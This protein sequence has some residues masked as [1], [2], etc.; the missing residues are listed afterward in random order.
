MRVRQLHS[1]DVTTTQA[2]DLQRR[3]AND[4]ITTSGSTPDDIDEIQ[5]VAGVDLSP[6]D[7]ETGLVRG[8]A[9]VLSFP[10]LEIV[11]VSTAQGVPEFP[12]VPGLLSF[13]EAPV[14]AEALAA[15][16]VTPDLVLV[17]GQGTAHPRRFGLACHLGLMIDVP[18]IGCAKSRLVGAHDQPPNERGASV[19]LIHR[20]EPI[21]AAVRTRTGVSPIYVS[22]GHRISLGNA[23]H[24]ATACAPRY[25]VPEPTRLAH[26]AAAGRDLAIVRR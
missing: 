23:T 20:D 19:P 26:F 1:W 3:L 18:T 11:E 22:V 17:D 6:P 2:I 25:R 16:T 8:A 13:R 5:T 24:W 15:L 12:Y 7:A 9:V 4:V 10:D 21:G 14:L